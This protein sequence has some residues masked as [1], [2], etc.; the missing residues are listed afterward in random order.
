[1]ENPVI[2]E[3]LGKQ[4]RSYN[5]NRPY[6]IMAAALSGWRHLKPNKRYW[7]LQDISFQVAPGEMLG[8]IGRN[9]AGKSSLLKLMGGVL[10]SDR[11][12]IRINGRIGALLTLGSDFH[13]DL[14]G[15]ENAV[16]NGIVGGLTHQEILRSMPQIIEFAELQGAIDNPVRTYSTGMKMRLA[17]S[18]AIHTNPQVMLIDEFLSVGDNAFQS[19]CLDRINELKAQGT[20]IILVSHN[21]K[22]IQQMCD[23][24]LWLRQGRVFAY[25]NTQEIVKQYLEE[26]QVN[27]TQAHLGTGEVIVTRVGI[28]DRNGKL[29]SKIDSGEQLTIIL[30]YQYDRAIAECLFE[31]TISDCYEYNCFTSTVKIAN[32]FN[33]KSKLEL[34]IAR[35]DLSKGKYYIDV[36]IY[37]PDRQQI[38]DRA[39]Q[40]CS[41]I[42]EAIAENKGLITPPHQWYGEGILPK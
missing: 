28:A 12:K 19:K 13:G 25:G 7:A 1:M 2:V 17:F 26:M 41:L 38:Y 15:R 4:Y 34:D 3:S 36:N 21:I 14:T 35:L 42:I 33:V 16:V 8:V 27:T 24:T 11:G 10:G 30:D 23:R 39:P 32:I 9:G 5:E 22:Q 29:L 18:V 31:V 40:V 20:A 6:T 37:S